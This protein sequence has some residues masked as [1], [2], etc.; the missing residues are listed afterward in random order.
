MANLELA[1]YSL[2][3]IVI[4]NGRVVAY[5]YYRSGVWKLADDRTKMTTLK[6]ALWQLLD[7][8]SVPERRTI[9]GGVV[10]FEH[11]NR[12]IVR[13]GD[14]RTRFEPDYEAN[15]RFLKIWW[16]STFKTALRTFERA[17]RELMEKRETA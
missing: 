3:K 15:T 14:A 9:L 13:F 17:V 2:T 16:R 11:E 7:G 12:R 10:V 5:S 8:V 4:E 6:D 1:C